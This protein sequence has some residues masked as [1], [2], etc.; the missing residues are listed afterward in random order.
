VRDDGIKIG[1][2]SGQVPCASTSSENAC[3]LA[4]GVRDDGIK[5]GQGSGQVPCA[6][7]SSENAC[8]LAGGVRDDEIKI[9]QG[10]GEVPCTPTSSENACLLAG[11]VRDDGIKIGQGSSQVPCASTSSE[12]AC[13]L[14]GDVRDDVTEFPKKVAFQA[15][16]YYVLDSIANSVDLPEQWYNKIK[17]CG[18]F[19]SLNV[20][21]EKVLSKECPFQMDRVRKQNIFDW[22]CRRPEGVFLVRNP[23]GVYHCV[24]WAVERFWSLALHF[25]TR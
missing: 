10:S 13:L 1:Q 6:P 22:L 5:I 17:T 25:Q 18:E 9:G 7:T 20:V 4:G 3:L 19:V 2:G 12:N 14:A 24:S 23:N 16:S 8:L 15:E 11:G 21:I